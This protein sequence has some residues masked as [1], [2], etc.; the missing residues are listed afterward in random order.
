MVWLKTRSTAFFHQVH[1]SVRG[2]S[3]GALYTNATNAEDSS[4]PITSFNSDGFT[5]GNSAALIADSFASQ[6]F[7]GTTMVSWN[8]RG[9]GTGVS[10]TDGSI[11]ST[12]SANTSAGFS[13][14]TYSGTG[15]NAT[16]GHGLGVAPKMIIVKRRN[17][18]QSWAVY[19]DSIGATKNLYL[20]LTDAAATA[21]APWNDTSPTST[22]F[23]VGTSA[24]TNSGSGTYVAYCFSEVAG[25]SKFSSYVGN[26]SSD[27]TFI[28]TGFKPRWIMVKRSSATSDWFIIDTARNTYN[29]ATT[30][31][32]A[33]ASNA[34]YTLTTG[35]FDIVSNGFKL[36]VGSGFN[37]NASGETY[38]YAAFAEHPFKYS[39]A[40]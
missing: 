15:S 34:D 7:S 27:G 37:P 4:Y 19:H 18:S 32:F 24:A 13:V 5:L 1:D 20:D 31:L 28:F 36:R 16:V 21:T 25:Y 17:T 8:W 38:V 6:N 12:V 33:N 30:S 22:V 14:V 40:R 3:A 23:S 9:G 10:N 29:E 2:A 26:G 39:L 35:G 11:T